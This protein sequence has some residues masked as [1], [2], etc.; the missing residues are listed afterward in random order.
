MPCAVVRVRR[1][2]GR[3]VDVSA[4][5]VLPI[6]IFVSVEDVIAALRCSRSL[7]YDHLRRAS[8]RP[9]GTRGLLR[10]PSLRWE[11]YLREQQGE[12]RLIGRPCAPEAPAVQGVYLVQHDETGPVKIGAARDSIAQR[13]R[14][15][16]AGNPYPL[17][18]R[19]VIATDTPLPVERALHEELAT[20]RLGGEWFQPA[21]AVFD[22]FVRRST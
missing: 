22:A 19:S 17:R 4:A 18:L 14:Q 15:L 3:G 2:D 21:P 8:G 1:G 9:A 7:A 5:R 13:L 12:Q 10:V 6:T 11:D 16:Q 20:F